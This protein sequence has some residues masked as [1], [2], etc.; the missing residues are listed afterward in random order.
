VAQICPA[1]IDRYLKPHSAIRVVLVYGPDD[2]LVAERAA[3]FIGNIT[4]GS[5][6]P[7][8]VVRLESDEVADDPARLADE[9]HAVPMFGGPRVILVRVSGGRG[10]DSAVAALLEAPPVDSWVILAAG[11][12]RRDAALRTLCEKHPGA[13][14]IP[15]R[16]D[17]AS[18]LDRVID[19]EIAAAAL[20]ISGDARTLLLG[21]I[22]ADRLASRSE[23]Q[24]LCL[25]AAD[26]GSIDIDDVRAAVGDVSAFAVD[27]AVD[28]LA[29]GDAGSF[30]RSFRRLIAAGTPSSAVIAAVQRHFDFLHRARATC[31]AGASPREMVAR[32]RPPIFFRRRPAVE[33]QI[34]LWPRQRIERALAHLEE[35]VIESRF[36][37]AIADAVIGQ[38][39]TLVAIVAASLERARVR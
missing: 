23:V 31:D 8:S 30:D 13:A 11:D 39:L 37:S 16:A 29:V 6:D 15:C 21:L 36:R 25:Y 18:D 24:K 2:G 26:A 4:G 38:A 7:F 9:A 14:A 22:G 35:A 10:I 27:E 19:E 17:Q 3:A 28:A 32:A 34:A 12:L 5:D 1:E 33:R 20:T